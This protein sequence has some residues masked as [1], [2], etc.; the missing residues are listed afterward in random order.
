MKMSEIDQT[1][2][3]GSAKRLAGPEGERSVR[4]KCSGQKKTLL[5]MQRVKTKTLLYLEVGHMT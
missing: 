3:L 1:K 4:F 2:S 5:S